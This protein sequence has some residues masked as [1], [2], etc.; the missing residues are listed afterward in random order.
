MQHTPILSRLRQGEQPTTKTKANC[1]YK[2]AARFSAEA[3][4]RQNPNMK[5]VVSNYPQP[6]L[7]YLIYYINNL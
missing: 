6:G 2:L 4:S 7:F 3:V 1:C 5:H